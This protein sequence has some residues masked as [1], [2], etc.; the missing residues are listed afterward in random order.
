MKLNVKD[1]NYISDNKKSLQT[2]L[3]AQ[4][5][6][7]VYPQAVKEG[8]ADA[9]ANPWMVDY[10]KLTAVLVKAVQE[11]STENNSLKQNLSTQTE[12]LSTQS[13]EILLLKNEM[14]QIKMLLK[15]QNL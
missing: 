6:Y 15:K 8:G 7:A 9:S 4:E 3:L 2:G 5:L 11:L 10:S 13:N 1:Y 12:K 14:E